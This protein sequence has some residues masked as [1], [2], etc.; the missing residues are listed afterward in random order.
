MFEGIE[1]LLKSF[2]DAIESPITW[3]ALGLIVLIF[4]GT[5]ALVIA[6]GR[7]VRKLRRMVSEYC[8]ARA[9][10]WE[11]T[12]DPTFNTM[13]RDFHSGLTELKR[14][15]GSSTLLLDPERVLAS[16]RLSRWLPYG[17]VPMAPGVLTALGL[18][19]TFFGISASLG[20]L[21]D[22]GT[23]GDATSATM[24]AV[25]TALGSAFWTSIV[26]VGLGVIAGYLGRQS[27]SQVEYVVESCNEDLERT[28]ELRKPEV[29]ADRALAELR[30][31][32]RDVT[33]IPKEL[34]TQLN[35]LTR[36]IFEPL[37]REAV[38]AGKEAAQGY[39][40]A[41]VTRI[42]D[43]VAE[44][45]EKTA[46]RVSAEVLIV[47]TR[48]TEMSN[49]LMEKVADSSRGVVQLFANTSEKVVSGLTGVTQLLERT[50]T[51]VAGIDEGLNRAHS[52]LAATAGEI[53]NTLK[54]AQTLASR[55]QKN[56][57]SLEELHALEQAHQGRMA[58]VFQQM[59]FV[60]ERLEARVADATALA[61]ESRQFVATAGELVTALG[62]TNQEIREHAGAT[63]QAREDQVEIIKSGNSLM[64]HCLKLESAIETTRAQV[65]GQASKL[66]KGTSDLA[67]AVKGVASLRD[68][69]Q[70]FRVFVAAIQDTTR[71]A[72]E[73]LKS[74]AREYTEGIRT[75][76]RASQE[77][78]VELKKNVESL[79]H[80]R[81]AMDE[82][83]VELVRELDSV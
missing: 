33:D 8:H 42:A 72:G 68:L 61:A 41:F 26:G 19:G 12:V 13:L 21:S 27:E 7:R 78:W 20:G 83:L 4:A 10:I 5:F 6:A 23:G 53:R 3:I 81:K 22:F 79:A 65:D 71:Q 57:R 39:T 54:D 36:E 80:A 24:K 43:S 55:V 77:L 82:I 11:T 56:M 58:E 74:A 37:L 45:M 50:R 60:S 14:G 44:S 73:S 64:V 63:R 49:A 32:R 28:F 48:M 17:L 35:N 30:G 9:P 52:D 66:A 25:I 1:F 34:R 46:S 29:D 38:N 31:L 16:V 18:L 62:V 67:E 76:S 51:T 75:Q 69:P 15:L 70:E 2:G 59:A 40:D 47:S